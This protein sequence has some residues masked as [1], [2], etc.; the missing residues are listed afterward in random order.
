MRSI[1][2]RHCTHSHKLRGSLLYFTG[3]RLL[4]L[5]VWFPLHKVTFRLLGMRHHHSWEVRQLQPKLSNVN[6]YCILT[7]SIYHTY[8]RFTDTKCSSAT[9]DWSVGWLQM[10]S[11]SVFIQ[12]KWVRW[13]ELTDLHVM[14][15]DVHWAEYSTTLTWWTEDG[16]D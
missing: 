3:S 8:C 11:L 1:M 12:K 6:I 9:K 16:Q 5:E 10:L 4:Q 2:S 13:S 14:C 15:S 7:P